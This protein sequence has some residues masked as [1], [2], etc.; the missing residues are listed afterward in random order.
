MLKISC[1][2]QNHSISGVLQGIPMQFFA[3]Q[4]WN[5]G[6]CEQFHTYSQWFE[7]KF[8]FLNFSIVV[9]DQNA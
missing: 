5:S 3:Q 2:K 6:C 9:N 1:F 8:V 4:W 7:A